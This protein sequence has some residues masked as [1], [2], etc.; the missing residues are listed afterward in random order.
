[1]WR[2]IMDY[3]FTAILII[4]LCLLAVFVKPSRTPLKLDEK[5]YILPKPKPKVGIDNEEW[6]KIE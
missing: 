6:E 2:L 5:D 4:L 1:M 3:K